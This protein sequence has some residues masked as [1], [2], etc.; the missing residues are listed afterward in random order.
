[1]AEP[2][3][4]MEEPHNSTPA[5][6]TGEASNPH[7]G[8]R[9]GRDNPYPTPAPDTEE[10]T[11]SHESN[12]PEGSAPYPT[13]APDT[14]EGNNLHEDIHDERGDDVINNNFPE[15]SVREH[16]DQEE[17]NDSSSDVSMADAAEDG[18]RPEPQTPEIPHWARKIIKQNIDWYGKVVGAYF[19]SDNPPDP[20][21]VERFFEI[22][23][24][25]IEQTGKEQGHDDIIRIDPK[26]YVSQKE[27]LEKVW[28]LPTVKANKEE[29]W[30]AFD[31]VNSLFEKF[32]KIYDL[33]AHW[34]LLDLA[35]RHLGTRPENTLKGLDALEAMMEKDLPEKPLYWWE[36]G[37]GTQVF[38]ELCEGGKSTYR[39][40][41]G[42]Y[43]PYDKKKVQYVDPQATRG[44]VMERQ[45]NKYGY[46][47][48][49]Y[50]YTREDVYDVLGV[51]WKIDNDERGL[52]EDPLD[53]IMPE[54]VKNAKKQGGR[55]TYAHTK[56]LIKWKDG[57]TTL[58]TREFFRRIIGNRNKADWMIYKKAQEQ[59]NAYRKA[60]VANN[61]SNQDNDGEST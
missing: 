57:Q 47:K 19:H 1:M 35:K 4:N 17:S 49:K 28:S 40:R 58:E 32:N 53:Y 61:D 23:N 60:K 31:K 29:G 56:L 6:N 43:I 5:P 45:W 39:I 42:S 52:Q 54:K 8:L 48:Q 18:P 21:H 30:K 24:A 50:K 59:E 36:K 41:A 46:E 7:E 25:D 27:S 3:F 10:A 2:E 20:I 11:K 15:G 34:N 37:F 51:G 16:N 38:V 55:K 26:F 14:D 33:P 22:L 12:H 44:S 9:H 13:P